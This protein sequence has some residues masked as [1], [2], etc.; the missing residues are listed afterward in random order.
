MGCQ[1][2]RAGRF[3]IIWQMGKSNIINKERETILGS[4][5]EKLP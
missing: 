5:R 3:N 1:G 2:S 4:D